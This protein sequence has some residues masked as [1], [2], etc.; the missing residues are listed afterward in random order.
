[1]FPDLYMMDQDAEKVNLRCLH[2]RRLACL[3]AYMYQDLH[4]IARSYVGN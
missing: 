1:M 4:L 2:S 3:I